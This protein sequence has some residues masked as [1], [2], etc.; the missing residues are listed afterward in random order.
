MCLRPM[1]WE[2]ENEG[3]KG[4]KPQRKWVDSLS[5]VIHLI[6]GCARV[7]EFKEMVRKKNAERKWSWKNLMMT[8]LSCAHEFVSLKWVKVEDI[9]ADINKSCQLSFNALNVGE[10]VFHWGNNEDP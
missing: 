2:K 7:L 1:L 8:N 4:N 6:N 9:K 10:K 3:R 5:V